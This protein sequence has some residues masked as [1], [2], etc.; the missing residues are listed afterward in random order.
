ML[1]QDSHSSVNCYIFWQFGH[2]K[3]DCPKYNS[4]Y[5]TRKEGSSRWCCLYNTTS[6]SDDECKTKNISIF[7]QQR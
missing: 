5:K 2:R 6:P 4:N 1:A 7:T 3:T